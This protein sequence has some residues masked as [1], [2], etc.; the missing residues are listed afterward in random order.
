MIFN[1]P[2][3]FYKLFG[4]VFAITLMVNLIFF[5]S[6]FKTRGVD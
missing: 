4:S 1:L 6:D 2:D 5:F 3:Y